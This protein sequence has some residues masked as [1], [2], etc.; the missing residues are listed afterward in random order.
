M[1]TMFLFSKCVMEIVCNTLRR[2][3]D[4]EILPIE[5]TATCSQLPAT[6][7]DEAEEAAAAAD[8]S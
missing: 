3:N 1:R 8:S 6:A 2:G 5:A 7:V 4:L